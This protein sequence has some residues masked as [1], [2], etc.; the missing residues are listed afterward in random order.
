MNDIKEQVMFLL[1]EP[2]EINSDD[3]SD[4]NTEDG[5]VYEKCKR[6]IYVSK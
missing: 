3:W 1:D 5:Q 2:F 6:E 4:V